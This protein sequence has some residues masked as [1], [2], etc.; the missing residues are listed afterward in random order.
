MTELT[1]SVLEGYLKELY[2]SATEQGLF[3]KLVEEIGE[4]AEILNIRAGRKAGE[5][6][7]TQA[8]ASELADIIH[9]TAAIAAINNIDLTK[10]IMDKDKKASEKYHHDSL[11]AYMKK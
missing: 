5:S 8:L 6:D 11:E 3:M 1:I 2:S 7:T 9:Y 10:A 4:T